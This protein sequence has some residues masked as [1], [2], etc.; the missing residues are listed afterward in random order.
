LEGHAEITIFLV[1][2]PVWGTL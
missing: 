1:V 2:W